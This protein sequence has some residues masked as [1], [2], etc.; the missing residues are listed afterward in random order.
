M[1]SAARC[2][3]KRVAPATSS[4]PKTSRAPA[5]RSGRSQRSLADRQHAKLAW[6]ATL[7]A[8]IYR[9]YLLKEQLRAVYHADSVEDALELLDRWLKWARRCRLEPFVKLARR[10]TQQRSM[11]EASLRHDLS[12]ARV[13]Q[14]NTQLRLIIR[15]AFGFHSYEAPIALAMLTLG[16]LCPPLPGR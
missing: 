13:E 15:R 11:V 14:V 12:N 5:S 6:I 8:P 7:N 1:R 16:G 10:I 9:A 4:S 2:G 3:T